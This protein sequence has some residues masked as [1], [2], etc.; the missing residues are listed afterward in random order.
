M[1]AGRRAG[2]RGRSAHRPG[3]ADRQLPDRSAGGCAGPRPRHRVVRKLG[4]SMSTE[5]RVPDAPS[6][7]R[8]PVTVPKLAE[9]KELG[10]Q[11]VMITAYDF[12]SAQ[13]AEEAGVDVI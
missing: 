12:P 2:R 6:G 4:G 11:I 10:E 9:M 13:V 1:D 7:E 8:R 5:P 3:A